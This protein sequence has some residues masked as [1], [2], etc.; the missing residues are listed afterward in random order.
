MNKPLAETEL[1]KARTLDALFITLGVTHLD[2]NFLAE[3]ELSQIQ[4]HP[5]LR[6]SYTYL[7]KETAGRTV[8]SFM[9]RKLVV[10]DGVTNPDKAGCYNFST[11]TAS[12]VEN[13]R[14]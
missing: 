6:K 12:V 1:K 13:D 11:E 3:G 8:R 2:T 4:T 10:D 7:K 9:A 5:Q 14:E